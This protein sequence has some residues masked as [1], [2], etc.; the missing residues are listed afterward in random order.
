MR[1]VEGVGDVL[2]VSAD[3]TSENS[4]SAAFDE[5]SSKLGPVEVL[6]Y[7]AGA[8]KLGRV[9]DISPSEFENLWKVSWIIQCK[10]THPNINIRRIALERS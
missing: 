10:H 6:V 9:L 2:S 4:V 8:F 5:V 3:A 7:N 1:A